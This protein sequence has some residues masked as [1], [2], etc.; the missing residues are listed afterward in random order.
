MDWDESHDITG[1]LGNPFDANAA[2]ATWSYTLTDTVAPTIGERV[3]VADAQVSQLTQVEITFSEPVTGVSATD[4]LINGAP[5]VSVTGAG[6]GPYVFQFPQPPP[7]LVSFT[8]AAGHGITDLAEFPNAFAGGG[9]SV[10]LNPGVFL[11]DVIIN[12]FVAGNL[13]GLL[14][15]DGQAQDWIE[16]YNRGS[17]AVNLLGWS[18]TDDVKVPGKWVFPATNLAP[19]QFLVV[20]ASEKNRR[21]AGAP[22]H[23][24]FKLDLFGEYLGLYN[25]E[26]PRVA[27]S[28][29]AAEYPEQRNDYS[30]GRSG[31]N[32]WGYYQ[33]PTPGTANGNSS[34]VGIAPSPH[35]SVT[36]GCFD[37]PFTL[38][39][40]T[41]LPGAIIRYTTDGSEPTLTNGLVYSTPLS[42]TN[43]TIV[44]AASFLTGYL[45]SRSQTHSYLYL[46]A[47]LAQ[48]NNPP[49]FPSTWGTA[50]NFPGNIVPADYEMDSDPLRVNP[51]DS[52]S[53]LDPVKLQRFQ[54]GL[55]ELP[56]VSLVLNRDDMFGTNG[57]YPKSKSGDKS[58]NEKP[59]SLEMLLPDGSTGFVISG[60]LDLHGNASRDPFKN[61]KHGFKVNFKGDY[62][63]TSLDYKLFPD[64]PAEKFDDLILRPDFGVSWRHQTDVGTEGLGNYQRSR[65]ARFRDAWM[66][67]TQRDMGG[68]ASYNRYV[69]LFINGLYWGTYDIS[70][71]P[72]GQFAENYLPAST[73]GYDIYDQGGVVTNAGGNAVVYNAMLAVTSLGNNSSYETMKQYLNVPEFSDYML[74]CFWAGAQD[75]GNNKNWYAVRPRVAGPEGTFRYTVWDGENVL[76]DETINRVPNGGGSTDVP[77]GIFTKLDDNAQYRLDFADRVHKHMVSPGGALTREAVT[78]RWQGWQAKLDKPIVAESCR[79]GDYRRDVHQYVNGVYDLYTREN[80][81]LTEMD[82]MVNSY[83][84]NRPAIVMGQLRTAGLYPAIDAPEYRL[85]STSG[86]I[87]GSQKLGAGAVVALAN[88]NGSGAIY[89]TTN[90][91]D[92]RVYY[93]GAIAATALTNPT[94]FQLNATVTLKSRVWNGATWSALN[95]A[96]FTVGELGVPL[97]ITE[98]M[99]RSGRWRCAQNLSR[100]KML[101]RC[102]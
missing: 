62:G 6:A 47:V 91:V 18:L 53:A 79:W 38:L 84:V 55:R 77:S 58:P 68:L 67:E 100:S 95:E 97:R 25:A 44:R 54:D 85:G 23:T 35:F 81:W 15:A 99:S 74:L 39:L 42:I 90:G 24:N 8:W 76:L 20:F 29:L 92:P 43:T 61:P 11:G 40:T 41:S 80:Q 75:W 21:V 19:G 48:P 66:K 51:Y 7:G 98:L 1:L 89:C 65:A 52:G 22:L 71:Q 34:I 96:T 27:V 101:A 93:S 2:G 31:A 36:R 16:I 30:Y 63:E 56:I 83:F 32:V 46:N 13:N 49:G 82:R 69:H 102:R 3:P 88:P 5:A 86:S 78:A 12:E 37:M 59:I 14:D 73:N 60:G 9:W 72:V 17:N 50:A 26:S 45:P 4:L 87:I 10:S 33:T 70:E 28:E 64:S 94:A 57:L